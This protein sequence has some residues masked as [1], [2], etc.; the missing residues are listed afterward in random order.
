MKSVDTLWNAKGEGS[1]L[2]HFW[3]WETKARGAK[4][5][6]YPCSPSCKRWSL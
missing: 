4:R 1:W 2:V 3:R 5:I 6:R